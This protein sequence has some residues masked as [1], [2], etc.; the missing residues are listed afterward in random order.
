MGR[1]GSLS[2]KYIALC[3]VVALIGV[4]VHKQMSGAAVG[5]L[6]FGYGSNMGLR[7]LREK[8]NL[9]VLWSSPAVLHGWKLSFFPAIAGVEPA[10]AMIEPAD[11]TSEGESRLLP[12][13]D[14]SY[15]LSSP[16]AGFLR[17]S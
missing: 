7:N 2:A 13:R 11:G 4:C 5:T 16:R 17:L 10:F 8:K 12:Q 9:N 1:R 6:R 15:A 3:G 14:R